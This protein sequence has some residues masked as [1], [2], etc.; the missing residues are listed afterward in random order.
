VRRAVDDEISSAIKEETGPAAVRRVSPGLLDA[1]PVPALGGPGI[2]VVVRYFP[3]A[4][5]FPPDWP[6]IQPKT[7]SVGCAPAPLGLSSTV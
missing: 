5:H 6:F 3:W 4:F 7:R 1:R 2:I